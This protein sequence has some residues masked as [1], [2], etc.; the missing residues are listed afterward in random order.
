MGH[1]PSMA[2]L[3]NKHITRCEM[4]YSQPQFDDRGGA[5]AGLLLCNCFQSEEQHNPEA[6]LP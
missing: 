3:E 2:E 4:I 1:I 6:L 5:S